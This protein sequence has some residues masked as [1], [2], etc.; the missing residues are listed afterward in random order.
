MDFPAPK[1]NPIHPAKSQSTCIKNLHFFSMLYQ[2][3]YTGCLIK[4]AGV[5]I[6]Y[7]RFC[8]DYGAAYV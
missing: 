2:I 3:R 7:Y 1:G 8:T 5:F 6:S 4:S